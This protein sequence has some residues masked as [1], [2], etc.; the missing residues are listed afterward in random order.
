MGLHV[1]NTQMG[2]FRVDRW[3]NPTVVLAETGGNWSL[4]GHPGALSPDDLRELAGGFIDAGASF[5]P[6][7]RSAFPDLIEWS[8]IIM[9]LPDATGVSVEPVQ[10]TIRPLVA[11]DGARVASLDSELAWI[12]STWDGPV[13]LA[14][15]GMAWGAFVED[16]RLVSI[17]C[18]FFVGDHYE[19]IG[20]VTQPGHRRRGFSFACA[21]ALC[22]DIR[23][24]G[25]IPS[26]ST[27][28]YNIAS[29]GVAEKL[30][31]FVDRDDR[32]FRA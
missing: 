1:L 27:S 15:S 24:R 18:S 25:R 2:S 3:P 14:A 32:L 5:E 28:P 16:A 8:R 11:R 19:D 30:G 10:A 31:F 12:S 20:I 6:L 9:Q 23:A 13:R 4:I 21:A 26:W 17:A 22:R 7:L 29:Q